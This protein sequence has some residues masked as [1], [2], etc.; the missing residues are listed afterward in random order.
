MVRESKD[1]KTILRRVIHFLRDYKSEVNKIVWPGL[2]DVVKNTI[3]VLVVTL[4]IGAFI[5]LLD[6]GLG[7]LMKLV[8]TL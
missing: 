2:N 1:K 5:W 3:V 4:I 7:Q 6:F 8:T